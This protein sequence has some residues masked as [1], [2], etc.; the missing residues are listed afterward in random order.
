MA[1][2]L[3]I[4]RVVVRADGLRAYLEASELFRAAAARVGGHFWLFADDAGANTYF[5]FREAADPERLE[6]ID[7]TAHALQPVTAAKLVD[8]CVTRDAVATC[9]EVPSEEMQA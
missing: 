6:A 9:R 5:E 4:A 8:C 1:R 2:R 3:S 7:A